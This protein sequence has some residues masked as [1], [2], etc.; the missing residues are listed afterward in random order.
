MS[1][2]APP[3][4]FAAL[5]CSLA[6]CLSPGSAQAGGI[7]VIDAANLLQTLQQV[8][9]DITKITNQ[10]QQIVQLQKQI[11]SLSGIR[12]LGDV[13][14]NPLLRNYVP[15][16]AYTVLNAVNTGG[17]AGLKGSAKA[18]R[19]L[20]MI[21][22]CLDRAGDDRKRCQAELAQPYQHKPCQRKSL[23]PGQQQ[24]GNAHAQ[25][26]KPQTDHLVVAQF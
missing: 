11:E 17:Y 19:D 14:N 1:L 13:F 21:Y 6:L 22:N 20:G 26:R 5:G 23:R 12:N 9:A 2:R 7:P 15:A 8:R 16:E 4:T 18:L 25:H 10:V 3:K 24:G